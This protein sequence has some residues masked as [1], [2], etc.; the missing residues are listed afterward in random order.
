MRNNRLANMARF[1]WKEA[2]QTLTKHWSATAARAF[3]RQRLQLKHAVAA[4]YTTPYFDYT[5]MNALFFKEFREKFDEILSLSSDEALDRYLSGV[6]EAF[7]AYCKSGF[8][9]GTSSCTAALSF[10]LRAL[11]VGPGDEVVTVPNSY[12]ATALAILDV[13]AKPVFA[14]VTDDFL[15]DCGEI[16]RHITPRTKAI[17]PVHLYGH[18]CDMEQITTIAHRHRLKVVEDGAQALG[19]SFR[20]RKIGAWGDTGCFSLH[21]SKLVSGYGNG[22]ML[23]THDRRVWDMAKNFQTPCTNNES[24]LDSHRTPDQLNPFVAAFARVKLN[25]LDALIARRGQITALYNRELESI[26]N[27]KLPRIAADGVSAFRNYTVRC[28]HRDA[29]QQ[30]L[31]KEGIEAKIFYQIPLHLMSI[32]RT[33]GYRK[34]DFPVCERLQGSILS[35]PNAPYLSD[36]EVIHIARQVKAFYNHH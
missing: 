19:A 2:L 6:D 34:G 28:E 25:H 21:S 4:S 27:I 13:G 18:P 29:L 22:G 16:E 5:R 17:L 12:C 20:G 24:V 33:L 32:F 8:A 1:L 30:A 9:L 3:S 7:R 36:D 23:V 35:L 10:S 26:A 15:I 31:A 11:G 14:D